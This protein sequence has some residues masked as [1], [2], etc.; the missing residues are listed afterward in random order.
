MV[1]TKRKNCTINILVA[2]NFIGIIGGYV[3][4]I[5]KR[6]STPAKICSGLYPE[7]I[8]YATLIH[9]G[10]YLYG[11]VIALPMFYIFVFFLYLCTKK[12]VAETYAAAATYQN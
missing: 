12:K 10:K 2:V 4:C 5:I 1:A 3:L 7:L 9:R 11:Y 6:F 8:Q